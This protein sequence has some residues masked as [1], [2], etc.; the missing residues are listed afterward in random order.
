M[1][2]KPT[3]DLSSDQFK[4]STV[5]I[6]AKNHLKPVLD[7]NLTISIYFKSN[8]LN[9]NEL[10]FLIK[11]RIVRVQRSIDLPS[12]TFL[13]KWTVSTLK[14]QSIENEW[15]NFKIINSEKG[16]ITTNFSTNKLQDKKNE[17]RLMIN[18]KS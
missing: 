6:E 15:L 4:K 2:F 11:P 17:Y 14:T 3:V 16:E 18:G 8:Q 5:K 13:H 10:T 9:S 12:K 1:S 7:K